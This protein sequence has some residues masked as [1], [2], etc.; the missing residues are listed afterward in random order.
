NPRTSEVNGSASYVYAGLGLPVIG[1]S[2]SQNWDATFRITDTLGA[3]LGSIARRLRTP[4]V[5]LSWSVPH[6]RWGANYSLGA[7]YEMRR[8]TSDVDALLGDAGSALRTGTRY[9]TAYVSGGVGTLAR[10]SNGFSAEQGIA[11]NVSVSLRKREG[12]ANSESWR[13]VAVFRA[14]EPLPLPGYARH[15]LAWRISAGVTDVH[16]PSSFSIGGT[17]GV[18][19]EV[20]PG[21]TIGDPSRTFPVRGFVPGEQ[22]GVRAVATSLEYRAPLSI[23]SRGAGLFPLF[24]DK[25]SINAFG[26]A[27]RASCAL[28]VSQ[29]APLLCETPGTRD[30]WLASVGAELNIDLALQYDVPYRLRVGFAKPVAAPFGISRTPSLFVT[31]G[32]FF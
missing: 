12:V 31:L 16:A 4:A 23:I 17:S 3:P 29:Q 32:S 30:G 26:D 10:G 24:L 5:S 13:S 18:Q 22:R 27:G 7:Q 6:I 20:V 2:F 21:V 9:P 8:F 14:Y 1:V 25:L 28:I 11:L 19:T 15:V